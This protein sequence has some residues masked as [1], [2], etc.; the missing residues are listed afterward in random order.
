VEASKREPLEHRFTRAISADLPKLRDRFGAPRVR[1]LQKTVRDMTNKARNTQHGAEVRLGVGWMQWVFKRQWDVTPHDKLG[2]TLNDFADQLA[3]IAASNGQ[4]VL[5]LV[6]NIDAAREYDLAGLNEL[7]VH[8]E[9]RGSP[10]WLVASGGAMATSRLMAASDRMSGIA[11][12]ITNQFD[13]REIGPLSDQQLRPA[14]TRPLDDKGISYEPEAIASLLRA[15]NGDPSRLRQLAEASLSYVD[16]QNGLTTAAAAAATARVN[17]DSSARYQSRW[18]ECDQ[19]AE[20]DLLAKVAVQGPNGLSMP[21]QLEAAGAGRWQAIDQ[22]R[23]VLVA[24]GLLREHDGER[25][26]IAESGFQDWVNHY[27]DQTPAAPT[28]AA[29]TLALSTQ[30]SV[31]IAPVHPTAAQAPVSKVFGTARNPKNPILRTDRHGRHISLD[32]RRPESPTILFTGPPGIGTSHELDRMKKLADVQGWTAIRLDASPRE[33][34]EN[35]MIRAVGQDMDKIRRRYGFEAGRDL[36]KVLRELAVRNRSSQSGAEIRLGPSGVAQVVAKKQWDDAPLDTVGSTL[37]DLADHLGSLAQR[38]NQPIILLVD[39]LDVA[40]EQDLVSLTELS[41]HLERH[42]KGVMVVGAGGERAITRLL[43]ASGGQS[44]IETTVTDRFDIREV[45]PLTAE[46]L[47]PALAESFRDAGIA[48][49]PEAVDQLV[50]ASNGNPSRLRALTSSA[51]ELADQRTGITAGVAK[52]AMAQ[53][54]DRSR[55]LY[56]AAWFNCSDAEK[57]LL[58]KAALN[59]SHGLSMPAE[60]GPGRWDMDNASQ[61]LLSRGLLHKSGRRVAVA[62]PGMQDWVQTRLGQAAAQSGLAAPTAAHPHPTPN[63]PTETRHTLA[64]GRNLQANR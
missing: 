37:N 49:E 44:G 35:R 21:E 13:I 62:D 39:N 56:E 52:A 43:A 61:V 34:L 7:A 63:R 8:L 11:T 3:D 30:Q 29:R 23:Q 31:G 51:L 47:G 59:G 32:K 48:H 22:A 58:A 57:E 2:T 60:S 19:P 4:P 42:G 45:S 12:T 53:L 55:A 18:N 24:R 50:K 1:D 64:P 10:V 41:A 6:D 9:Q 5:L 27:L 38:N 17:A 15:A 26:T 16:H 54:N 36:Q 20:K 40:S 46:Q 33:S 28:E 25:V 14:L